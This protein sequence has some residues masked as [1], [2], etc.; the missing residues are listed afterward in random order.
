MDLHVHLGQLT[1]KEFIDN[2]HYVDVIYRV[3]TK[4]S[5][6]SFHIIGRDAFQASL[7]FLRIKHLC[8]RGR[9]MSSRM[10]GPSQKDG[11]D[12]ILDVL[13]CA[14]CFHELQSL[15][16][17]CAVPACEGIATAPSTRVELGPSSR[18]LP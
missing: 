6:R 17:A 18:P 4:C 8:S 16:A 2:I 12:E 1:H 10:G 9:L 7:S 13:Y 11:F 5:A 3:D 15:R 14:R